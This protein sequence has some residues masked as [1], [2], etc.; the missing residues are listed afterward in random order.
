MNDGN[1][2]EF[3]V[4]EDAIFI[5]ATDE[6]MLFEIGETDVAADLVAGATVWVPNSVSM[7]CPKADGLAG[8]LVVK[9]WWARAK[10]WLDQEPKIPGTPKG[11]KLWFGVR[12][13]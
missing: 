13:P 10:G 6:A 3:K 8:P 2:K 12:L 1:D 9:E 4:C 5:R 11:G 7:E